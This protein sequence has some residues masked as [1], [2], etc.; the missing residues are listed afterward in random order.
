MYLIISISTAIPNGGI[1]AFFSIIIKGM[2]F[3]TSQ[4][5]LLGMLNATLTFWILLF[6]WLGD[7]IRRRCLISLVPSTVSICGAFMLWFIP[8]H[9]KIARLV[10]YYL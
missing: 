2:G 5:L 6:P 3:T 4:T 1:T 7:K 10:G 9:N 8:E